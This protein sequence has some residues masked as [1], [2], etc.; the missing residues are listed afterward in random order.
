MDYKKTNAWDSMK[1]FFGQ[2]LDKD[3]DR[4]VIEMEARYM[5][6]LM[7]YRN[8]RLEQVREVSASQ[9]ALK[10]GLVEVLKEVEMQERVNLYDARV[11]AKMSN[12]LVDKTQK[13]LDQYRKLT[14]KERLLISSAMILGGAALATVGA[15]GA[16]SIAVLTRRGF[17]G[18]VAGQGVFQYGETLSQKSVQKEMDENIRDAQKEIA[19]TENPDDMVRQLRERSDESIF[20]SD[21]KLNAMMKSRARSTVAGFTTAA[22]FGFGAP[23]YLIGK[24]YTGLGFGEPSVA[25]LTPGEH[26]PLPSA[27][28]AAEAIAKHTVASGASPEG[29]AKT[30]A[31]LAAEHIGKPIE[32]TI[33]PGSGTSVEGQ[34]IKYLV[35]HGYDPVEAGAKAHR[36]LVVDYAHDL[37]Q[38]SGKAI[39]FHSLDKILSGKVVLDP[40]TLHIK[41]IDVVPI[42]AMAGHAADM[43]S[44]VMES[45]VKVAP[46]PTGTPDPVYPGAIPETTGSLTP[47]EHTV[48]STPAAPPLEHTVPSTPAAPPLEH[49]APVSPVNSSIEHTAP[50]TSEAPHPDASHLVPPPNEVIDGGIHPELADTSKAIRQGIIRTWLY[51]ETNGA[52]VNMAREIGGMTIA[53]MESDP[54]EKYRVILDRIMATAQDAGVGVEMNTTPRQLL[55]RM[56]QQYL[57]RRGLTA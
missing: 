32:L 28:S 16:A 44:K 6:A 27:E 12:W 55:V 57:Q 37:Q 3:E 24:V 38:S 42:R 5:N 22:F 21:T 52:D 48:P 2:T 29:A 36:M 50:V 47:L 46:T 41:S 30:A 4:D 20:G 13:M 51:D 33:Q 25:P 35:D 31:A 40:E 34:I 45:M 54:S 26:T 11:N 23:Q 15:A 39:D 53:Q 49:T 8:A 43:H 9:E 56:T 7:D 1:R 10:Q 14:F 18:A 17:G 19:F